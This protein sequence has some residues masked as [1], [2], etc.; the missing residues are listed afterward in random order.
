MQI[1]KELLIRERDG[2]QVRLDEV[3]ASA[4]KLAGAVIVLNDL[5]RY[6]EAEEHKEAQAEVAKDYI[7]P[8]NA[9]IQAREEARALMQEAEEEALSME[10]VAELVGGPGAVVEAVAPI[11]EEDQPVY[12]YP[13]EYKVHE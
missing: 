7:S 4:N 8:E 5:I 12:H 11:H 13:E 10:E 6:V 3:T 1:T 9:A 2:M